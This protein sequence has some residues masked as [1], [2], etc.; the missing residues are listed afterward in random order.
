MVDEE[1]MS[2]EEVQKQIEQEEFLRMRRT[3][4]SI[5]INDLERYNSLKKREK[6]DEEK[7]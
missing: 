3:V 6:N 2:E 5:K 1:E 4:Q 7:I